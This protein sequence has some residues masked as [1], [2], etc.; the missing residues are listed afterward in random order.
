MHREAGLH[1]PPTRCGVEV[2]FSAETTE[3]ENGNGITEKL[4]VS[5][6]AWPSQVYQ[7]TQ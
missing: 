1:A 2:D 7:R 4:P 6:Y 5:C 3:S